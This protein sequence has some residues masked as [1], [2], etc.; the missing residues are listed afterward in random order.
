M[1][2]CLFALLTLI[3]IA[4][5]FGENAYPQR[6]S[7]KPEFRRQV[8]ITID[9]LPV[10]STR[11]EI[12][13]QR[14]ITFKLLSHVTR[15]KVPAIGFVN[16][17]KLVVD[18]KRDEGRIALLQM[19]L[20]AGLELGNH[21]FS[22]NSLNQTPLAEFQEDVIRGEEVTRGLLAAKSM[23]LRY[24]RHPFLH[25]GREIEKKHE[26]EKFL[27]GRGYTVAPVTVDNS[28]WLF[29]RAYDNATDRGDKA[30]IKRVGEAYV[31]YM[32]SVFDF[33]E[34]QSVG[35]FGREIKQILLIHAN[36]INA[37]YFDKLAQMIKKR[38]YEFITLDQ[39]LEDEAYK[40]ADTFTGAGGISWLHRWAITRN[41]PRTFFAGEPE[42]PKFV[43]DLSKTTAQ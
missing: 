26:F 28:D 34:K 1:K 41:V 13:R 22:H 29:A 12:K 5:S 4:V 42:P 9:D 27:A 19:W 35:L 37:D 3:L 14:E 25:T 40:S 10:V 43:D 39:A 38:G 21:T 18:G 16:E 6:N 23:K 32:E 24:F 20:N 11:Q 7:S 17:S 33:Y 31:P 15:N 36:S 30:A 8:A 2:R